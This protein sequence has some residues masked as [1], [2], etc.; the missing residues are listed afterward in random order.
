[1]RG[2]RTLKVTEKHLRDNAYME[3][4][5]LWW[6]PSLAAFFLRVPEVGFGREDT[7]RTVLE[8]SEFVEY[9][10]TGKST[11]YLGM[12]FKLRWK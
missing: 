6:R 8:M 1:M 5:H 10:P 7:I 2:C 3:D 12:K 11:F 4:G 9:V